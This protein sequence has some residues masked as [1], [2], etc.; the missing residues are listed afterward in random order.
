MAILFFIASCQ[1][2]IK[3]RNSNPMLETK[4]ATSAHHW[5]TNSRRGSVA[6]LDL[7][8]IK[9]ILTITKTTSVEWA[10][11]SASPDNTTTSANFRMALMP[12][13]AESDGVQA[14]AFRCARAWGRL[15]AGQ[16]VKNQQDHDAMDNDATPRSEASDDNQRKP[17]KLD[18]CT[19]A[20]H[21]NGLVRRETGY[22]PAWPLP[23]TPLL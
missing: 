9:V 14:L 23:L 17:A 11:S 20:R 4:P 12:S 19:S 16:P 1:L 13:A 22:E 2:T 21:C 3:L 10:V 5:Q 18:Q 6:S 8:I 15:L 7:M